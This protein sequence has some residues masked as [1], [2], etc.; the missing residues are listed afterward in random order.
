MQRGVEGEGWPEEW[1]EGVMVP[2]G[3]GERV[4]EYRGKTLM[5]T[6]YEVYAAVLA[7]R[8]KEEVETKGILPPSQAGFR[9]SRGTID[10]IYVLNYSLNRMITEKKEKMVVLFLDMRAAFNSVDRGILLEGKRG[11]REW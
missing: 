4:E 1:N 2:V 9:K 6:A 10:Q 3:K 5:Q 11:V 7:E 8:L